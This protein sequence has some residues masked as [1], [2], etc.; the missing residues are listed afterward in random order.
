MTNES[1]RPPR[2]RQRFFIARL[3]TIALA[4]LPAATRGQNIS[5]AETCLAVAQDLSLG[6][7][8]PRVAAVLK[9]RQPLKIVAIGS[10]STVGLWMT[11]QA[12]TY[13]EVMKRELTRLLPAARVEI[14]NSGRSGDTIPRNIARFDADVFAH[15]PDLVVWQMGG[16]DFTWLESSESLQKKIAA[17]IQSIKA[18]GADVILMDQQYTPMILATQYTKIQGA[19]AGA[20]QQEGVGYFSRFDLMR[21]AVEAG[22]PFLALSSLDGLHMSQDGY[23]C[24][25]R[26]LARAIVASLK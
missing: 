1:L 3:A 24:I 15:R 13:P 8:L 16:N 2:M 7:K 6:A 5:S 18:N 21:R 19:I 10:S 23:D 11:D 20:A 4:F 9:S 14:V 17:G 22:V 25:G 12:K 26:G